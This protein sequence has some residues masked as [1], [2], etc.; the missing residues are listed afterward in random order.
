[1]AGVQLLEPV[2]VGPLTAPNRVM[3]GPLVTN[4]ADDDRS[5]TPRHLAFY[6][7]RAA[8]GCGLIVTEGASVHPLDWP[9][10]RAPLAERSGA[11]WADISRAC[12]AHG[13]LVLAGLDHAGGQ[14]SSA[15]SQREMWAPSRVPEV[16]S[17][18]VPKWMEPGDI[19]EVIAGFASAAGRAVEAGCDGVELNAGQ[20]SLIRQFASGLTNHRD[21][22]WADRTRFAREV[23]AVVR[24]AIGPDRVLGLRLSCD[25]LAPWAG[26]TAELA[27]PMV[28]ELATLVDLLVVVRGSIFSVQATRPDFHE[29]AGFNIDL[30]RQMRAA[31]E[32]R[33]AVALQ[34]SVIDPGQAEWAVGDGVCDLV[35]MTRAQLADASMVAKLR[36]GTAERIRPCTRCNQLCQVRDARNPIVGCVLDP[37]TGYET[38]EPVGTGRAR[39]TRDVTVIGAG[40]AGLEAARVAAERGHRVT[41]VD[42]AP[43]PGG[44]AAHHGPAEPAIA[45]LVAECAR[46]GVRFELGR[47]SDNAAPAD[48]VATG[49]VPG[50]RTYAI[51]PGA[52]VLDVL[53]PIPDDGIIAI[54][55]PIGGP[56]AVALA[57]QLG[58]R[59]VLITPDQIAGN[60]L[61]RTGDLAPANTRLAQRGVRLERRSILRSVGPG[62]VELEDRFT[63]FRRTVAADALIDAGF[64]LPD[65]SVSG[66]VRIGDCVAPRTIGD[67]IREARRAAIALG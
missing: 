57:E 10:E 28:A 66:G 44:V 22:E 52:A 50:V 21:D 59:A 35:E 8:G 63:G 36:A 51:E 23:I 12:H 55:D 15:Y 17:R 13:T 14:G 43:A 38:T 39:T 40:A 61:S 62:T 56:I 5:F 37:S 34:G 31:A 29:P 2:S 45:W 46:L 64:R 27:A 54:W 16:A 20:H 9:Y 19:A 25:E 32:G 49:S 3:F 6:E 42:Q 1:M 18:E 48:I 41:V 33:C 58:E 11:G 26:I 30:T 7:R 47:R 65:E 4:L 67:A 60:E 24:S 53:E